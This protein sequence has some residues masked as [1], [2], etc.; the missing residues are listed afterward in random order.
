MRARRL[1]I[2]S[3]TMLALTLPAGCGS[4]SK[5]S[6]SGGSTTTTSGGGVSV[7]TTAPGGGNVVNV[8][9]GDTKGLGGPMTL[10]ADPGTAPAGKV[11]FKVTNNGTIEHEVVLLKL[12]SGQT[13]DDTSDHVCRRPAREGHVRRRQDRRREQRC[14]DR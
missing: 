2:V 14:R 9:V 5:S 3:G 11:T 4:S 6:S 8:T 12:S 1:L 10:A 7:T 13:C